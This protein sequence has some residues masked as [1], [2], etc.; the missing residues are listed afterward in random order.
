MNYKK[1]ATFK[2]EILWLKYFP[3]V[4]LLF[5][6][7]TA[8]ENDLF[9]DDGDDLPVSEPSFHDEEEVVKDFQE[10]LLIEQVSLFL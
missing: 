8:S 4:Y 5:M 10:D 6:S 1:Y 7:D 2:I 9:G 3:I